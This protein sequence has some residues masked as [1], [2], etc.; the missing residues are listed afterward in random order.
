MH[1]NQ[2]PSLQTLIQRPGNGKW[3][4][5]CSSMSSISI[6]SFSDTS[7]RACGRVLSQSEVREWTEGSQAGN[8]KRRGTSGNPPAAD[9][10]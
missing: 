6:V 5:T 10:R 7:E 4:R 9:R 1:R 3:H 2:S 8:D